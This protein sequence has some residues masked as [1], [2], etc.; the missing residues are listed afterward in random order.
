MLVRVEIDELDDMQQDIDS[1]LDLGNRMDDY[2]GYID[3]VQDTLDNIKSRLL[4]VEFKISAVESV[5]RAD[6]ELR[7]E[8]LP[9]FEYEDAAELIQEY[10][11]VLHT[12]YDVAALVYA[13]MEAEECPTSNCSC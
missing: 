2:D 11:P 7:P 9:P 4:E 10:G 8:T 5:L 3:E 13:I 6:M 12:Y 1:A